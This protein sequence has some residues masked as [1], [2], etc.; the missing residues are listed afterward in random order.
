MASL[1]KEIFKR[2]RKN[3]ARP[4]IPEKAIG[5]ILEEKLSK[6]LKS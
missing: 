4:N 2:S 5:K 6:G 3:M 1:K